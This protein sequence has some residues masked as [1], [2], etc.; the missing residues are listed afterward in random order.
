MTKDLNDFLPRARLARFEVWLKTGHKARA[1]LVSLLGGFL[2]SSAFAPTNFFPALFAALAFFFLLIVGAQNGKDAF[3][4]GWWAGFGFFSLGI[5][6]MGHSFTQQDHVPVFLAPFATFAL[7]AVMALYV[8]V[9]FWMTWRLW[10]HGFV[11]VLVFAAS[12][13]LLEIAR[14]T[15]FTGFPWHL[16]GSAWAEWTPMAQGAYWF[17]VYGLTF[18]T[19]LAAG[20]M[21]CFLVEK[22]G[23]RA[24]A[25]VGIGVAIM[26]TL[27]GFGYGRIADEKTEF[28]LSASLKL[29]QANVKQREKWLSH[30]VDDHFDNHMR[31]SRGEAGKAE[32]TKLLIWPETAVQ[33]QNFDRKDSLLRWRMSRLLEYNSYAITGAPRYAFEGE[34]VNY[35][36]SVFVINSK[37][38]LFARYDKNHLV[39]FGE[40][41]PFS[42]ILEAL[43]LS[44]LT[45]G[46]AYTPG[47]KRSMVRLPGVPGFVP[48]ICYESVFPGEIIGAGPRPEWM[49]NLSN[50]AWFGET[51]GP[52]QHLAL[53]RM[54]AIEEGL[55][56]VRATSTGISAVIDGY[57]R[58]VASLGLGRQGVLESPLPKALPAPAVPTGVRILLVLFVS[59]GIILFTLMQNIR[60]DKASAEA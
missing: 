35:F 34:K 14:G 16:V 5:Y 47:Q 40:Y 17:S 56:L 31:L 32:G 39:P 53:T 28:H 51:G 19:L 4:R 49:L 60:A 20:F 7:S 46:V 13:T 48:L 11:R 38:D 41:L 33:R 57:G 23:R 21:G 54:R 8:A 18:I 30:R 12:W 15:W 27:W 1:P 42:R 25:G 52:H 22:T 26:L 44:Q 9:S 43:G 6:W 29:V 37:G 10:A 55:P 36:N 45:G 59:A 2:L 58:T 50:D 24:F 3:Q